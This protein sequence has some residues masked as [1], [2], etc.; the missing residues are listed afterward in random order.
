MAYVTNSPSG[1]CAGQALAFPLWVQTGSP[2]PARTAAEGAGYLPTG[3]GPDRLARVTTRPA[4]LSTVAGRLG[5][6]AAAGA[7]ATGL[8]ACQLASPTTTDLSYDPADGVSVDVGMVVVRDLLVVSE[9]GGASGVVSG[10][11]V[12]R[13]DEPVTVSLTDSAQADQALAPEIEV[14]ANGAVRLDG[15][16]P[17]EGSAGEPVT[18]PAV[19]SS[20]GGTVSIRVSTSAGEV[21]SA[22]VPVLLPQNQYGDMVGD[23]ATATS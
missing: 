14:P 2:G 11:V 15:R 19:Q 10:L 13:S 17:V 8:T 7:L 16:N 18:I 4:L 5:A 23:Q 20:A 1:I 22:L 21:N 12:N 9:G 6:A 3:T